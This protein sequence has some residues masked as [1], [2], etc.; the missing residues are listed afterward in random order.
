MCVATELGSNALRHTAS[1]CGGR[2]AVE[3]VWD[4]VTVHV[5]V[6]D[7]GAPS[8]P[9]LVNDPG[10]EDGRGLLL[11]RGL[12]RA[13]GVC[14]DE[15]GRLVWA[16]VPWAEPEA[17][18]LSCPVAGIGAAGHMLGGSPTEV[19]G[20][21]GRPILPGGLAGRDAATA[22]AASADYRPERD[23]PGEDDPV[24]LAGRRTA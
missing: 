24:V 20:W 6:Y 11:V 12:T 14:G 19:A 8:G 3:I 9:R 18:A 16:D 13:Y 21:L 23:L 2:F 15:R 1:G 7:G 17:A 5:A 4:A 22:A 10:Q